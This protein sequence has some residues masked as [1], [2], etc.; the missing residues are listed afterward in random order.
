MRLVV[1]AQGL[2]F[3]GVWLN[4]RFDQEF[5]GIPESYL[6]AIQSN[7]SL[8]QDST[9]DKRP[10]QRYFRSGS[11]IS[12]VGTRNE[13]ESPQGRPRSPFSLDA[14]RP[15]ARLANA[16]CTS[17]APSGVQLPERAIAVLDAHR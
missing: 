2:G 7:R 17:E 14:L 3:L 12:A 10:C 5:R 11:R 1:P 8:S 9:D 13:P 15:A 16:I 4:R 6:I